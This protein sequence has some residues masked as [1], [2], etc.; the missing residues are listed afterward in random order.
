MSSLLEQTVPT[1]A[2]RLRDECGVTADVLSGVINETCPR[3][4]SEHSAA[5]ARL[6]RLIQSQAWTDAALAMIDLQLPQWRLR[7]LVYDGGEWHCALS[8]RR[9][10]PDWLDQP[11]ETHHANRAL[12]ILSAFAKARRDGTPYLTGVHDAPRR[13]EPAYEPFCSE[14]FA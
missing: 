14:N 11:I 2:D 1:L 5:A 9:E 12:A 7:R 4:Q 13:T 3:L 8:R 10:L 6:E